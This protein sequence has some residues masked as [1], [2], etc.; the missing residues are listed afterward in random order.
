[1][2]AVN[3]VE[4]LGAAEQAALDRITIYIPSRATEMAIQSNSN[5]GY[6]D[7]GTSV[8]DRWRRHTDAAGAGRLVKPGQSKA[9]II[10]EVT[11]VYSYIDAD[12]LLERLAD[13]RRLLHE[14]GRA[15]N[16]GE[17]VIEVNDR[18]YRIR[19]FDV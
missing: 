4:A 3:L 8:S 16:Q 17:V 10:E 5:L 9:L 11:L 19:E 6:Q 1:M 14:I 2:V 15:L 13:L 18:F 7:V 12:A